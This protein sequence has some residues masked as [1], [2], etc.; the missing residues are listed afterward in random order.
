MEAGN[1]LEA[2][3]DSGLLSKARLERLRRKAGA[4]VFADTHSLTR[5]LVQHGHLTPFQVDNLIRG[6][7]DDLVLGDYELRDFLG[8]GGMGAV[9]LARDRVHHRLCAVK[10]LAT[11]HRGKDR[12]H[13]RFE[14][15]IQLGQRL[16][17]PGIAGA[18]EAKF[19]R[20]VWCLILEY[21]PGRT[22]FRLVRQEGPAQAGR[23]AKWGAEIA[24]A[25]DY[26]HQFGVVHRDLK[27]SNVII[28]PS[29]DAKLLDMGLARWYA[30]DHNETAIL[31]GNRIV[32][33]FDYMAPEQAVNSARADARSDI[34]GL[35]CL[36]YF[37]L[38]GRPPFHH[39][40][41]NRAKIVHHRETNPAPIRN[42]R[43]DVPAGLT[44][45]IDKMMAKDPDHRYQ[46]AA[47]VVGVLESWASRLPDVP[48]PTSVG[49][50]TDAPSTD[51]PI[52]LAD[53]PAEEGGPVLVGEGEG[54]IWSRL[55]DWLARVF[56]ASA[57]PSK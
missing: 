4:G 15:E 32:G 3:V 33:S 50:A 57:G 56:K 38:V 43:P 48:A 37:A 24:T 41:E 26:A 49:A 28:T 12:S 39:V 11:R 42:V 30:D 23:V 40:E 52:L 29:D 21:V 34:Y 46:L 14:R 8:R 10:V 19:I 55:S 2:I 22:L 35:G 44:E 9:F 53:D 36:L 25:L 6:K 1:F 47:E 31:G 13:R 17:H 20:G 18:Y 45:A 5:W 27:P 51:E 16:N 7:G 54:P